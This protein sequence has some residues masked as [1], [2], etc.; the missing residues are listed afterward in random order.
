MVAPAAAPGTIDLG[1]R[2]TGAGRREGVV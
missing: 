2:L 1:R